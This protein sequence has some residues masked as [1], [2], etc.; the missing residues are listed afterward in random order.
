ME[1]SGK[2]GSV[3]VAYNLENEAEGLR[4]TRL[5]RRQRARWGSKL[6]REGRTVL[7]KQC[8]VRL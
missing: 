1:S 3:S 6:T 8:R 2:R 4:E 7:A 5:Q